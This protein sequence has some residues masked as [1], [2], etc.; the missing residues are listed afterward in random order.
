MGGERPDF[1]GLGGNGLLMNDAI[2]HLL[3]QYRHL[4]RVIAQN[5]KRKRAPGILMGLRWEF[6]A[7]QLIRGARIT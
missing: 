4:R 6:H 7:E 5:S 3:H 1:L 2:L